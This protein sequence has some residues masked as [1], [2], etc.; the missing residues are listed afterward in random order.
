MSIEDSLP[1]LNALSYIYI[2]G[3]TLIINDWKSIEKQY[4]AYNLTNN[5][6]LG[7]FG[8]SGGGPGELVKYMGGTFDKVNKIIY[9]VDFGPMEIKKI[10]I[11]KALSDSTY[12]AETV[13]RIDP[14]KEGYF[15][16]GYY[17]NDSV[18]YTSWVLP[19]SI[20][21]T[22]HTLI[23]RYNPMTGNV[24]AIERPDENNMKNS[25]M[26]YNT[27][28][29]CFVT[30]CRFYD[31]MRLYDS[32]GNLR[33]NIYGPDYKNESDGRTA[34]FFGAEIDRNNNIYA[35]YCGKD[36][37]QYKPQDIIVM[38]SD[39]EYL[40]TIHFDYYL[41]NIA[42]HMPTHR[43]YFS[44]DGEPQFGYINLSDYDL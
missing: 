29:A 5:T 32:K 1:D 2:I 3:D 22:M 25:F 7:W 39:G 41:W 21:H 42:Y 36:Y 30:F 37:G 33:K 19:D 43:L 38:N 10:D 34:Y 8:K 6:G 40:K 17:L 18:I 23:V 11:Q 28:S 24:D 12:G 15:T 20:R 4:Y 16:S 27:D 35:I 44:M 9:G 26:I 13:R 14:G 31:L